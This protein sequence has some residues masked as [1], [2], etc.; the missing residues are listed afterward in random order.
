MVRALGQKMWPR[1]FLNDFCPQRGNASSAYI[2]VHPDDDQQH[3]GISVTAE[4]LKPYRA[5]ESID[6]SKLV[7]TLVAFVLTVLYTLLIGHSM[8]RGRVGRKFHCFL[9]NKCFGDLL[10][11]SFYTLSPFMRQDLVR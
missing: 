4:S 8:R 1:S 9:L 5:P 3:G 10:F 7:L 11:L 6:W 2:S